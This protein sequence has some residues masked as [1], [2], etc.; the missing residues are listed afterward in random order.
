[1]LA[2]LLIFSLELGRLNGE[3]TED[4][5]ND[6]P[7]QSTITNAIILGATVG[8]IVGVV[9]ALPIVLVPWLLRRRKFQAL[10]ERFQFS[11]CFPV[12]YCTEKRYK[13]WLK[14]FPWEGIGMLEVGTLGHVLHL[15][16]NH[17]EPRSVAVAATAVHEHGRPQW[18]RNGLLA[19]LRLETDAGFICIAADTGLFVLGSARRNQAM[20]SRI[21][22]VSAMAKMIGNDTPYRAIG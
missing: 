21:A 5:M 19:W 13:Q 17:G 20:Y 12:K 10:R 15:Y 4:A 8:I 9:T 7:I 16:P 18:F 11:E 3:T 2:K 22:S 14:I 1:M 6:L